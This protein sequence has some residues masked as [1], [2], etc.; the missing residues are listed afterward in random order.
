MSSKLIRILLI[1]TITLFDYVNLTLNCKKT[2]D[3]NIT[4]TCP[5]NT[6]CSD[7]GIC[8]CPQFYYGESCDKVLPDSKSLYIH[9][10]GFSMGG[11]VG[12]ILSLVISFPSI[13]VVGLL[14]IFYS[15]KDIDY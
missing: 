9:T 6:V 2:N 10:T 12:L 15:L 8:T 3:V 11:L 5:N 14:I 1:I 13:L 4:Y 7:S